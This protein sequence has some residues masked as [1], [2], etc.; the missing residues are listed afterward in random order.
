MALPSADLTEIEV[1]AIRAFLSGSAD[2]A[3][4]VTAANAILRKMCR[5]FDSPYVANGSDR[6]SF[7]MLGRHQIG[8]L[9]TS[10]QTA[11]TLEAA[12]ARD[13]EKLKPQSNGG[14]RH[15]ARAR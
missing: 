14:I 11:E 8:V 15:N 9:I 3:A 10:A 4:Q 2:H 13:L 12:R 5:I 7:V 6:D 1:L